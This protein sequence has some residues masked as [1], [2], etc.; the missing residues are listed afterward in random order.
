MI[1]YLSTIWVYLNDATV[2]L[3]EPVLHTKMPDCASTLEIVNSHQSRRIDR[4]EVGRRLQF[5][6][7][8]L[9]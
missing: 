8:E 9:S 7:E 4:A 5:A 1:Y 6:L 2:M 3:S